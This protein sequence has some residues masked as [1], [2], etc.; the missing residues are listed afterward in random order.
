MPT[1]IWSKVKDGLDAGMKK[2]AYAFFEKLQESDELPGLH[3]EPIAG[4]ADHRVR[5]GRVDHDYRCI[6]FKI[7]TGAEPFYVIHG[8]W[9][10]DVANRLAERVSLSMNPING[11]PEV[12]E[13]LESIRAEG[14]PA[15]PPATISAPSPAQAP[16]QPVAPPVGAPAP[17]EMPAPAV[18]VAWS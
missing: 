6:L 13:V 10:H 2:K 4:S 14:A 8:I 11:V 5:T 7:T 17:E 15:E 1:L 12:R 18:P 3:I 9:K 16:H